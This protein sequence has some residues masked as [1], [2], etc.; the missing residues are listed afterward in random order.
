MYW[1]YPRQR[2]TTLEEGTYELTLPRRLP[3]VAAF[4]EAH[5][6]GRKMLKRVPSRY[7]T[8]RRATSIG[9]VYN[10]PLKVTSS[11]QGQA[12]GRGRCDSAAQVRVSI[13]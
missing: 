1:P 11:L 6:R 12:N 3:R 13:V 2:T 10:N 4:P 8:T 7:A 5:C 9:R